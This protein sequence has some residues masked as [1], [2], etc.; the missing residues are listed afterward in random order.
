MLV[1]FFFFMQL[2]GSAPAFYVANTILPLTPLRGFTSLTHLAQRNSFIT[3]TTCSGFFSD[4]LTELDNFI[5]DATARRLGNGAKFYGKR[6]SSFYG[7]SD[8]NKKRDAQTASVDEDYQG[9]T[10]TGY[11][12]WN[13]DEDGRVTPM[14]KMKQRR[15]ESMIDNEEEAE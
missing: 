4:F 15:I 2:L 9:P 5:D 11:F 10:N 14:T 6:K 13:K 1:T 12:I 3:T 7:E 8:V